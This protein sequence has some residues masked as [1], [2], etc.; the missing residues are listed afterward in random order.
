MF[1]H[2][3]FRLL[4]RGVK[5]GTDE[6]H[7]GLDHGEVVLCPALQD[8]ARTQRGEVGD[9]G[10][11]KEDVLRQNRHQARQDFFRAPP[12]AL[13]VDDVGL[14]EHCTAISENGHGAGGKGDLGV[15]LDLQAEA[16]GG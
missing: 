5:A 3:D 10:D 15:L 12:L 11:V 4:A 2:D 7:F 13:E 6:I 14:E 9:A 8:E 1:V 16:L